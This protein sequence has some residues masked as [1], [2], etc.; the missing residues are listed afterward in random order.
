MTAFKTGVVVR[1]ADDCHASARGLLGVLRVL[2]PEEYRHYR[3]C[4]DC[5]GQPGSAYKTI[6]AF[7]EALEACVTRAAPPQYELTYHRNP[8]TGRASYVLRRAGHE[9]VDDPHEP[10]DVVDVLEGLV[11]AEA[12]EPTF[13]GFRE[14]TPSTLTTRVGQPGRMAVEH[15]SIKEQ[16]VNAASLGSPEHYFNGGI[17]TRCGCSEGAVSAF[18]LDCQPSMERRGK[19]LDEVAGDRQDGETSIN[20]M[21]GSEPVPSIEQHV[22]ALRAVLQRIVD[23]YQREGG[24]NASAEQARMIAW[25]MQSDAREGLAATLPER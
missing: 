2:A 22:A 20:G 5:I 19:P 23:R 17:C 4:R 7:V 21:V 8:H 13:R 10:D 6:E 12:P 16:A 14:F 15:G 18:H 3:H 24:M 25:A 9:F 1:N 11:P